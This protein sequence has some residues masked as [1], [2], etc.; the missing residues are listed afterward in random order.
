MIKINIYQIIKKALQAINFYKKPEKIE[1]KVKKIYK[2]SIK[3][4]KNKGCYGKCYNIPEKK[5]LKP[6]KFGEMRRERI[7]S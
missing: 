6:Y 2:K 4:L 5:K 7:K 1:E 3:I